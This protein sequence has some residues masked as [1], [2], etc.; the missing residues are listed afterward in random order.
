M[1]DEGQG[2][3]AEMEGRLSKLEDELGTLKEE[4]KSLKESNEALQKRNDRLFDQ[5]IER[6]E[7]PNEAEQDVSGEANLDL[8]DLTPEGQR[9]VGSMQSRISKLQ[10]KVD[11]SSKKAESAPAEARAQAEIA[12][13]REKNP[14]EF[15][16]LRPHCEAIASEHPEWDVQKV[17]SE[18]KKQN[19][20]YLS[21]LELGDSSSEEEEAP[22]DE[23]PGGTFPP[24]EEPKNFKEGFDAV[25]E[26]LDPDERKALET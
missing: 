12:A 18:A 8:D 5:V 22:K 13:L 24:G 25:W 6:A 23:E 11:E 16:F 7:E 4:N 26:Q 1:S 17:Y 14:E 21:K 20:D 9:I 2:N 15:K 10:E 3:E 19:E